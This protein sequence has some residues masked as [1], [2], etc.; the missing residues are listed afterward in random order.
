MFPRIP[1]PSGISHPNVI[2]LLNQPDGDGFLLVDDPTAKACCEPMLQKN[3]GLFLLFKIR[4]LIF[5]FSSGNSV[6]TV[7]VAIFG[8]IFVHF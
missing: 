4:I 6:N 2:P 3:Y 1:T 8:F 7:N 5:P